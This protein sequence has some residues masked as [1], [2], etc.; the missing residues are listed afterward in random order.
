[1]TAET[2]RPALD[3][4]VD[5][6]VVTH[7]Y[8]QLAP[9]IAEIV[10]ICRERDVPVIE[11]CAQAHGARNDA[12]M[13]GSFGDVAAFSFYP[14]KN[15]GAIGDGGAVCTD[16]Q[17][18]ERVRTLR[19][20]G[21]S[22]K[23]TTDS[24]GGRN[25]RLDELQA[26]FLR[27]FLPHLDADNA[28]RV[29]IAQRYTAE[30]D[31]PHVEMPAISAPEHVGHL[32]VAQSDVRAA[33]RNHLTTCEVATDIHYPIPDHMQKV[34]QGSSTLPVTERLA[35]RVFSLPCYPGLRDEAIDHV[36]ASVNSFSPAGGTS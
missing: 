20:Y 8:G 25:S 33:V 15:L 9:E 34:Y 16:A 27:T 12:G 21:W 5:A 4:G 13:A 10:A 31:S 36:V 22:K 7:L 19:Q 2:V 11:D 3:T 6:V 18:A 32:F 1:M 28:E 14:T 30:I 24:T 23:Y 17:H 35:E 26:A 29:R